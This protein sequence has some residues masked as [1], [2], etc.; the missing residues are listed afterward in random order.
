M[1]KQKKKRRLFRVLIGISSIT[2]IVIGLS[3]GKT[4]LFDKKKQRDISKTKE[5]EG[6]VQAVYNSEIADIEN[7]VN[8]TVKNSKNYGI[9]YK[10]LYSGDTYGYNEN[11][12]FLAASTIKVAL[13]MD[14]ADLIQDGRLSED[15][16]IKYISS[17]YEN[18]AGVLLDDMNRLKKPIKYTE[19]MDIAIIYSDNIATQML[20]RVQSDMDLYIKDI[21]GTDRKKG[22]NYLT[23]KQQGKVLEKLY[24]NENNN[25]MYDK[26]I[27]NMESTVFHDRIDQYV[28]EEICAH[29]IG[30]YGV[31]V[32]DTGIVFTDM[33]YIISIYTKN[34]VVDTNE[35]IAILSKEI[36]D[37][38]KDACTKVKKIEDSYDEDFNVNDKYINA[39]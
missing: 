1:T 15:G 3:I 12:P 34:K 18:G 2:L 23:A 38:N 7:V 20:Q 19:L 29:K 13:V 11:E 26:I 36:Y 22:G 10:N 25:S 16:S 4:Y 24:K 39:N 8:K 30:D 37:I 5:V 17:D 6:R 21:S 9:Y 27:K 14:I 33:P 28:P 32:H 31:Y 35:T